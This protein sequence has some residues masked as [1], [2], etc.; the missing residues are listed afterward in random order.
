LRIGIEHVAA[1]IELELGALAFHVRRDV[2]ERIA[3]LSPMW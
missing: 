1:A 2:V 3:G